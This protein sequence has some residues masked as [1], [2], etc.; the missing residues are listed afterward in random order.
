M[1]ELD[2]NQ[3]ESQVTSCQVCN[4]TMWVYDFDFIED[5]KKYEFESTCKMWCFDELIKN[6][7]YKTD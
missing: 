2:Y 3:S 7:D 5:D 1:D 4:K 6:E